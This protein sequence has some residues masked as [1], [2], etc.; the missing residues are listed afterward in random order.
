MEYQIKNLLVK[1]F[2]SIKDLRIDCSRINLFVG[3]PNVGKSNL[4]EAISLYGAAH[5]KHPNGKYLADLL[6]YERMDHLFYD[7]HIETT[8]SVRSDLGGIDI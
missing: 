2:K 7:Q 1:N 8:I 6:R 3:A 4:L 5:S